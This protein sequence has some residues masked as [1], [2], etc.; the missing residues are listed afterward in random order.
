MW[1]RLWLKLER[2]FLYHAIRLTRVRGASE[3]VARGFAIGMVVNLFPTFGFGVVIS[4]ALARLLGGNF[5]AGL[6]GG[7]SLT[8]FWPV[9]FFLNLQV[10]RWFFPP[11]VAVEHLEEVTENTMR[12]LTWGTTFMAGAI[13]NSLVLGL[14]AYLLLVLLYGRTRP[15]ALAYFRRHARD[16]QRAFR[17]PAAATARQPDRQ[18]FSGERR[19]A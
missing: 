1:R 3:R 5:V 14:L 10:G 15:A 2:G 13:L 11:A 8:F 19:E 7:A 16:H 4:G 12:T 9:L 6:V 17:R 18:G